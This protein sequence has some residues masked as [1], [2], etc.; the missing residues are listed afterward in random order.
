MLVFIRDF[1]GLMVKVSYVFER[2][3]EV[4]IRGDLIVIVGEN[5]IYY[6]FFVGDY[7]KSIIF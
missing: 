6:L 7:E 3:S 5:V 2:L 1:G 4:K